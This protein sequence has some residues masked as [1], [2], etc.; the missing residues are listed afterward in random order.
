MRFLFHDQRHDHMV[1]KV[2]SIK[3]EAPHDGWI[4]EGFSRKYM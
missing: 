3:S 4:S 2:K 1:H